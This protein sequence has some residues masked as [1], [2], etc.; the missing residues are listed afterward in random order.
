MTPSGLGVLAQI[1]TMKAPP[2][3]YDTKIPEARQ[4]EYQQ[5][6]SQL[7]ENLRHGT[8]DYDMQGAFLSGA[9][10]EGGHLTDKFK[11]PNHMT[12][13]TESQYSGRGGNVGGKW[14]QGPDKTWTFYASP[15]NLKHH[16]ADELQEYFKQYEP[17]NK[18]VLPKE[19]K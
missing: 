15:T 8:A 18:L 14:V 11:K 5:W 7:P 2:E 1:A 12:F 10:P 3:T 19:T 13:S 6:V 16:S 9:K 4:K 17:G